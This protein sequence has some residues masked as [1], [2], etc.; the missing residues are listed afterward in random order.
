MDLAFSWPWGKSSMNRSIFLVLRI[1]KIYVACNYLAISCPWGKSSMNRI[2]P[3]MVCC[4]RE[5]NLPQ[6]LHGC[7]V[8]V[9]GVCM[10]TWGVPGDA[11]V[12]VC[13]GGWDRVDLEKGKTNTR[14]RASGH[15]YK[16]RIRRRQHA[17]GIGNLLWRCRS[18]YGGGIMH[19]TDW[20][21]LW[22]WSS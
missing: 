14:V 17:L 3:S 12:H 11:D 16:T 20:Q 19:A 22:R 6:I 1:S 7:I 8:L 21:S 10:T 15:P 18:E 4:V 5:V 9:Q 13:V 2:D